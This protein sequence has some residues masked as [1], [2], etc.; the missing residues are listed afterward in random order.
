MK[1]TSKSCTVLGA[2]GFIGRHLTYYLSSAGYQV[3]AYDIQNEKDQNIPE[4]VEYHSFDIC[5][6]YQHI[7]FEVDYIFLLSGMTGTKNGFD[8]YESFIQINEIG[9][10]NILNKIRGLSTKP[11]V[12][13]PSTRLVYKGMDMPLREDAEKESKTIYAANK[14]AAE[15]YLQ[16]YSCVFDIPYI[17]YRICVPYGNMF[18]DNFSY[19]TIG[20]FLNR[21][22]SGETITLFGEGEIKRTLTHILSICQQISDSMIVQGAQNQIFNIHGETFS[23]NE[24][25]M[26]IAAVYNTSVVYTPWKKDD[27]II[28]SGSTVFNSAKIEALIKIERYSFKNWLEGINK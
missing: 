19:G 6:N 10:L 24:L 12:I 14:L 16:M 9:L 3:F 13:F 27:L 26:Q 17:I 21:A 20:F 2:N 1:P 11:T 18:D 25:A 28:E 7:N 22:K 8:Q 5:H 23:L 15:Q 4:N